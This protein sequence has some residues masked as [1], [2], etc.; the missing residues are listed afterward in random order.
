MNDILWVRVLFDTEDEREY[1]IVGRM[2]VTEFREKIEKKY[3]HAKVKNVEFLHEPSDQPA[4]AE[5]M[6]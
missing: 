5:V 3:P 2:P 6:L 1:A 4:I